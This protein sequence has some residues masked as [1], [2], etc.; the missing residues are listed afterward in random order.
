MAII[1]Q[2][3]NIKHEVKKHYQLQVKG[4]VQ[5]AAKM[6][7]IEAIDGDLVLASTKKVVS[8]GSKEAEDG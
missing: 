6:V 1:K 8:Q 5:K 4:M 2:A 3:K 7:V